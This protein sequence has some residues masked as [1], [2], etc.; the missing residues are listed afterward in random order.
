MKSGIRAGTFCDIYL[1]DTLRETDMLGIN[2]SSRQNKL[3]LL[4]QKE[5]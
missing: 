2:F 3:E 4:S 1:Q 5:V